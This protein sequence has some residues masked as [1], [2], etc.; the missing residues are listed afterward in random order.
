MSRLISRGKNLP[1][2][3]A[4]IR[5]NC[6]QKPAV[7]LNDVHPPGLHSSAAR[8]D[9]FVLNSPLKAAKCH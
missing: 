2:L 5:R 1:E 8:R 4:A 3:L 7:K 9:C 6:S